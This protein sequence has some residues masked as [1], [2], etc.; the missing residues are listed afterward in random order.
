MS[1]DSKK[2]TMDHKRI[3]Y[4][5]LSEFCVQLIYKAVMHDNSKLEEPE[6]KIFW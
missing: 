1:Y 4:K 6:K 2:D 3:V 5:F